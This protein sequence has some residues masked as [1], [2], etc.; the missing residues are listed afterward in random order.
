MDGVR[1]TADSCSV[2]LHVT[3][4]DHAAD[5]IREAGVPGVVLPWRDVLHEG[6]VP[7]VLPADELRR[8]RAKFIAEQGWGRYDEILHAMQER[9][10]MLATHAEIVLWFEHDLYD[11]LQL[12]QVLDALSY[13]SAQVE[14]IQADAYLGPMPGT[15]VAGLFDERQPVTPEQAELARRAW[16]A[17]RAAEPHSV[18][19]LAEQDLA[20]LPFLAAAL[21][22]HL[23]DL[24]SSSNGLSRSEQQALEVIA[25]D[26]R[27][28][29]TIFGRWQEREELRWMGDAPCFLHLARLA[30]APAPLLAGDDG[31]MQLTSRGRA[32]LEGGA[33]WVQLGG[34]DRWWGGVH[35]CGAD[36][37]WRWDRSGQELVTL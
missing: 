17:F 3:N 5:R 29:S 21:R 11:Q 8:V 1:Q 19:T 34:V 12:L 26:A 27:D 35:L 9:D 2:M 20:P 16:A 28:R 22:R 7:A 13:E 24:P 25:G 32:V 37:P 15:Q 31:S 36:L 10:A 18:A 14:L 33:D 6:P 30:A 4:G 23:E